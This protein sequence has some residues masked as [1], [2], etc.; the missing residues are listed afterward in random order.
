VNCV[1]AKAIEIDPKYAK[2]YYRFVPSPP[3][4]S[5]LPN[6][7]VGGQHATSKSSSLSSRSPTS[8]ASSLLSQR[9]RQSK[10]NSK[11]H[12]SSYARSS[13]KR[14]LRL[15]RSRAR[16]TDAWRSSQKVCT[17]SLSLRKTDTPLQADARST[18]A[19]VVLPLSA[20]RTASSRSRTSLWRA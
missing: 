18:K 3:I 15:A 6:R 17:C 20:A 10:C 16:S 8:S 12:R 4:F 7:D 5:A 2:A 13:S 9:T 14:R 11:A 1:I 19:T